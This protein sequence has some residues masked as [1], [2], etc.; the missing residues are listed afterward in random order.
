MSN[1]M[2]LRHFQTVSN[3]GSH[4]SPFCMIRKDNFK[5]QKKVNRLGFGSPINYQYNGSHLVNFYQ[6]TYWSAHTYFFQHPQSGSWVFLLPPTF[7]PLDGHQHEAKCKIKQS[8]FAARAAGRQRAQTQVL[9][10]SSFAQSVLF[11][12]TRVVISG[13]CSLSRARGGADK[14]RP[15]HAVGQPPA[16]NESSQLGLR[17]HHEQHMVLHLG[18]VLS[19]QPLIITICPSQLFAPHLLLLIK[20]P[21]RRRRRRRLTFVCEWVSGQLWCSP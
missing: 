3:F 17:V 9:W 2:P 20:K 18:I 15:R 19:E 16:M 13:C 14:G 10:H 6:L 5:A 4:S 8:C 12:F 1:N 11:V 21:T 7:S